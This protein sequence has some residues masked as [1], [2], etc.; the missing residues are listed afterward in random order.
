MT[1]KSKKDRECDVD[2]KLDFLGNSSQ[3]DGPVHRARVC[4][5]KIIKHAENG[6]DE[7]KRTWCDLNVTGGLLN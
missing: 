1:T 7:M 4:K 5:K 2:N 3:C 6:V